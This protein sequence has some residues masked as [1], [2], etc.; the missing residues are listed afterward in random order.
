MID[1]GLLC[2]ERLN[3]QLFYIS[4]E[5]M[6]D[7]SSIFIPASVLSV[8]VVFPVKRP[9]DLMSPLVRMRAVACE[10]NKKDG[11]TPF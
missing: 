7:I 5:N 6:R 4:Q 10:K 2:Q 11:T 1:R 8:S 9:V 3:C